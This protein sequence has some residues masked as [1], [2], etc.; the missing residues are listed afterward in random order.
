LSLPLF[1]VPTI[2]PPTYFSS[3]IMSRVM[4]NLRETN[5][6]FYALTGLGAN[7]LTLFMSLQR[8]PRINI[9]AYAG[10]GSPENLCGEGIVCN[11]IGVEDASWL[12]DKI[13]CALPACETAHTLGPELVRKGVRAFF[14]SDD[15]MF[16]AFT[17]IE[18]NYFEDWV[19]YT[20]TFYKALFSGRPFGECAEAYKY[21]ASQYIEWY[22]SKIDEWP[23]ADWYVSSATRNRDGFKLIGNPADKLEPPLKAEAPALALGDI[24]DVL[25]SFSATAAIMVATT[26]AP[27]AYKELK[28]RKII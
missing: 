6:R 10:H 1:V 13:I 4:S 7:R 26:V 21:K 5:W 11:M 19:D 16:A 12:K 2:V 17:E 28:E 18:H 3:Q 9:L 22:K 27:I 15:T 24:R 8:D 23:N 20:T 25:L 14:G